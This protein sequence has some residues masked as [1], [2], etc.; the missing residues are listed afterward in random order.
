MMVKQKVS[1]VAAAA[2]RATKDRQFR[3]LQ[4]EMGLLLDEDEEERDEAE[5]ALSTPQ[6]AATWRP[7]V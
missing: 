7:A 3:A 4:Q 2:A 5:L 6:K 1:K